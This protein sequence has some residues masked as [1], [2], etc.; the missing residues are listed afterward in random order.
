MSMFHRRLLLLMTLVMVVIVLL[1]AQV[2]RLSIF[3]GDQRRSIAESSL[4]RVT[5]LPTYRGRIIDRKGNVLARD[6]ASYEVA[7]DY[8]VITGDWALAQAERAARKEIG[9]EGW[10]ELSRHERQQR[11]AQFLPKFEDERQQLWTMI[12][13]LGEI[14]RDELNDRLDRI[15]RRVESMAAV[16]HDR[17]RQ[18]ALREYGGESGTFEFIPRPIYEQEATHVVLDQLRDD[19]ALEFNRFAQSRPGMIEVRDA[20]RREYPWERV[21]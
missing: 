9:R 13:L 14:D 11:A 20:H 16:V 3:E 4:D 2:G 6:R 5:Y 17:Q 8:D 10:S 12:C 15:K 7:V 1:G 19:I 21:E 18:S